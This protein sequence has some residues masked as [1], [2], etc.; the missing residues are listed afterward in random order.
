MQ[1]LVWNLVVGSEPFGSQ[2]N[3]LEQ[4]AY[5]YILKNIAGKTT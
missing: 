5:F 1:Y 3:T 4:N 2:L